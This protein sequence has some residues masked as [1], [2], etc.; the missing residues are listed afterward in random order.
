MTSTYL[1][2]VDLFCLRQSVTSTVTDDL[3]PNQTPDFVG[4]RRHVQAEDIAIGRSSIFPEQRTYLSVC[5]TESC[6]V[7]KIPIFC[8]TYFKQSHYCSRKDQNA[9]PCNDLQMYLC[10]MYWMYL[11]LENILFK[12]CSWLP[13][14][15]NLVLNVCILLIPKHLVL[16]TCILFSLWKVFRSHM[17]EEKN[18]WTSASVLWGS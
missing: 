13:C 3:F 9:S 5:L 12:M 7:T 14:H 17:H 11:I 15:R 16:S 1:A 8:V 18:L 2:S 4:S 6:Q 10:C